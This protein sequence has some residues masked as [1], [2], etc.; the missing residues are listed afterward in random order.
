MSSVSSS[1]IHTI[2]TDPDGAET[3]V[4]VS[5]RLGRELKATGLTTNQIR[6]LFSEMRMIEAMW[7]A[8][9]E[10]QPDAALQP[11]AA[12][13]PHAAEQRNVA[14]QHAAALRKLILLK[15]KMAYRARRERGRAVQELV[16]VLDEAVNE[17]IQEQDPKLQTGH[18][19]RFVEFF[20]AILAY[21]KAYGGN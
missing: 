15:P 9:N 18:F 11:H 5:D 14:S 19:T 2:V 6:A 20:E 13:Q 10:D 8:V 12:Q 17:V 4:K 21:H 16:E 1:E 3:L 7:P